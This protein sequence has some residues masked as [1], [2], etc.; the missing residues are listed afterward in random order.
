LV[1]SNAAQ[2]IPAHRSFTIGGIFNSDSVCLG[3]S[4]V[5]LFRKQVIIFSQ[6]R[7]QPEDLF[8][9][10][11]DSGAFR[12]DKSLSIVQFQLIFIL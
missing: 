1:Q 5:S 7:E 9:K 4:K 8:P 3:F 2:L 12:E 11:L 10:L 6:P